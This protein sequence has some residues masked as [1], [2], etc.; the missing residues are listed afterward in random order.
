MAVRQIA[1]KAVTFT[2]DVTFIEFP[3]SDGSSSQWPANTKKVVDRDGAVNYMSPQD[4]DG[5]PSPIWRKN[6]GMAV[7][8]AM[9]MEG[10]NTGKQYVLKDWPAGYGMFI[11]L[12]GPEK[13][14]RNDPYLYG[15]SSVNKF[16][17]S[18]EFSPHAIWLFMDETLNHG[19]CQCKY[20]TK[21]PQLA[22]S[23]SM[24]LST[25]QLNSPVPSAGGSGRPRG[26]PKREV[27]AK[28]TAKPY[29]AVRRVPRPK[30][31]Q[32]Q[33]PSV[34]VTAEK[35]RDLEE[36]LHET[37]VLPSRTFREGEVLWCRLQEPIVI[38]DDLP[39]TIDYWPGVVD[40]WDLKTKIM[41]NGIA[42]RAKDE[43]LGDD[44]GAGDEDGASNSVRASRR[45]RQKTAKGEILWKTE[46]YYAYK[47][48]LLGTTHTVKLTDN[49][50]LPYLA[51]SLPQD[52][53]NK[54]FS[55][56][57]DV[58]Q[59]AEIETMD[60]QLENDFPFDPFEDSKKFSVERIRE[61]VVPY[62]LAVEM[63]K[64]LTC[65]WTPTDQ[66]EYQLPVPSLPPQELPNGPPP[67]TST[68]RPH[69]TL[70]EAIEAAMANNA[71]GS[72]TSP[73][74][75]TGAAGQTRSDLQATANNLL[76]KTVTDEMVSSSPAKTITQMRYQ[77]LW[78]GAERIWTD[79]LVR[80][81]LARYQ[82]A[83]TGTNTVYPPS[84]MSEATQHALA[85]HQPPGD[86]VPEA[87]GSGDR[88]IFM[89]VDGLFV[90]D[91]QTAEGVI[92]ECRASGMLYELADEDWVDPREM[93]VDGPESKGKA[94]AMDGVVETAE[95]PSASRPG[96]PVQGAPST[97]QVNGLATPPLSKGNGATNGLASSGRHFDLPIPPRGF[98]F[99]SIL[100]PG[101]EVV[102]SLSLVAGR[103]YPR[104]LE[105]PLLT[106]TVRM[107]F[108][109]EEGLLNGSYLWALQG[110]VSGV[111]QSM[112]PSHWKTDRQFMLKEADQEA[113]NAFG[114]QWQGV[115]AQRLGLPIPG[116]DEAD[117]D[118]YMEDGSS[119]QLPHP[120]SVSA[121]A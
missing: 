57:N 86:I 10:A 92:K 114:Q 111:Y 83:P 96:T 98:K 50:A 29:T 51:Y 56:L 117:M 91:V 5:S 34:A 85:E 30:K 44:E 97:S 103:Y 9:G 23:Q 6:A 80:L 52:L 22:I 71:Q 2:G 55:I 100:P 69:A 77:G 1:N 75:I 93:V 112:E 16:R 28:T 76:G 65:Y 49:D 73:S 7:A 78:W 8:K 11:H 94:R 36:S 43:G 70:H 53:V 47:V 26:R 39:D 4:I 3:R 84:G 27:R 13:R 81:K 72:T 25:R 63:A 79:E 115:K 31:S 24:G 45:V 18:N 101:Q 109:T 90:A 20:S 116:E 15:S 105:H 82:F 89:L 35:V 74:Y 62:T 17:S 37:E 68:V 14:P 40:E 119:Q 106:E 64:N 46:Q 61:A 54:C 87:F 118:A 102:L 41:S 108:S 60:Q 33:G 58:M 12:K 59:A 113:R 48:K 104:I 38:S 88:G 66:Y 99:R 67:S 21:K 121:A 19:N 42:S 32:E 110:T 120:A 95:A 107:L